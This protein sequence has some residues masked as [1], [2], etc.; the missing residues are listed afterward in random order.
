M[1]DDL[2]LKVFLAP[3]PGEVKVPGVRREALHRLALDLATQFPGNPQITAIGR[4][5][6]TLLT[7]WR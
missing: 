6:E 5:L 4:R 7:E 2:K 1:S 3:S